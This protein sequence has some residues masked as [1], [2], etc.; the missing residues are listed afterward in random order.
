MS[1]NANEDEPSIVEIHIRLTGDSGSD[2]ECAFEEAVRKI[3][4]GFVQ[5][6]DSN[7]TGSYSFQSAHSTPSKD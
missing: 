3:K 1:I 2:I 5:G 7:D 6:F 4:Q